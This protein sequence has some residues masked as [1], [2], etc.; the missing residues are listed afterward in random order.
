M[1]KLGMMGT[2]ALSLALAVATPA[3]AVGLGVGSDAG[4]HIGGTGT[5]LGLVHR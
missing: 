3:F 1:L 5:I 2:T 4:M